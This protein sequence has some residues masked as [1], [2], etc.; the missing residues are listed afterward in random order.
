[1]CTDLSKA[2]YCVNVGTLCSKLEM[3][4]ISSVALKLVRSYLDDGTERVVE[5][6]RFRR[7]IHSADISVSTRL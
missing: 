7:T 2:F 3:Y 6:D 1:M 5:N 4:G